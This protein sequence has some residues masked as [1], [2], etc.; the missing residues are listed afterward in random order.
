[1]KLKGL[2]GAL[3]NQ[4]HLSETAVLQYT[5]VSTRSDMSPERKLHGA[6]RIPHCHDGTSGKYMQRDCG[7]AGK[8]QK[9]M[10]A[11]AVSHTRRV[12]KLVYVA[13]QWWGLSEGTDT[14]SHCHEGGKG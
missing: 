4:V 9:V 1:M 7:L 13:D 8:R 10:P 14:T 2:E 12:D 11:N 6:D 5:S 3:H